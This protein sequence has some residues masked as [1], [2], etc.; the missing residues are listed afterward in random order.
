MKTTSS[1][2]VS[3]LGAA[4][5]ASSL[6]ACIYSSSGPTPDSSGMSDP[7]S[8]TNGTDPTSGNEGDGSTTTTGAHDGG[9]Q[10]QKGD[11]DSGSGDQN[12]AGT[13]PGDDA[14]N[15]DVDAGEPG[16]DAGSPSKD[17]G[18]GTDAGSKDAGGST[19]PTWTTIYA[20]YF[21]AGSLGG[22]GSSSCHESTQ[23]GFKCGTTKSTCYTGLVNA[24]FIDTK[25]P[26]ES[27]FISKTDSPVMWFNS[28]ASMPI[29]GGA[30]AKAKAD[31]G[32]WVAAGALEN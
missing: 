32:A 29:G 12:D 13:N 8:S 9:P 21:G 28:N 19:A 25:N 15:T 26:S 22:C 27:T 30:S 24:G 2:L 23:S 20:D 18:A 11:V 17:A 6:V 7:V 1:A 4:L 14:G 3:L 5:S 31:I 16:T 10:P